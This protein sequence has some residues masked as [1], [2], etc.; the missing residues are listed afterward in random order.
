MAKLSNINGKF[1]VED[2]GA[3]RFSNQT[4]TTGQIL[5]SN[6][7]AAPTWVD[8]S[9]V[10][11]GPYLPLAG[12]ILT[13]AT[14]TASGISFTV[15]GALTGTTATFTG[16]VTGQANSNTFGTASASGR[17]LIVQAGSS[18]QAIMLKNNL[19]GDGTISATGT[20]TTMN[21]S[22]GTYSVAAL[23]IQNDGNVGIGTNSPSTKLHLGGTAPGDSI[24][25]QDSTTSGTNWEIGE[26]AAGKWQIFEDDGDSIVATFMSIGRVGIGNPS[27]TYQLDV[28][29]SGG[30]GGI[31]HV[32]NT[33]AQQYPRLAIQ[34]DVK[35]Y[36]IGVG[37]SGAAAGY[38]NNLY[39][40]D[41]N[42]AAIRMVIDTS[43]NVGIGVSSPSAKLEVAGHINVINPNP[44]IWIGESGSG[45]GGGFIGWNDAGD[46]LFLGHSYGS[47]FNKNIVINSSGNVGIGTDSPQRPLHVNG[48]EGVARFTSTASGNNGFEVGIGTA[49]QAFLWQTENSYMHFATNGTEKMRIEAGGN[50]GIGITST[51]SRLTVSSST[52]NNVANFKSS[53][54]TAY[55]AISDNSSSSA[56]GNQIGVVG[57]DMYFAVG[58]V[59]RMRL[60]PDGNS[61]FVIIKA[62]PATY[63]SKSFITLYGTNS[64]TYG[65]SV[66]ARSSI[67]SE[68]D[69]SAYGAN[70]KFYTNDSSNVEQT[71]L[72]ISSNG[73]GYYYNRFYLVSAANQGDLFFG[74]SDNQYNI[75]G[76]G[77]YGYMGYNTGGYH[78]FLTSGTQRMRILAN[79][80]VIIGTETSTSCTLKVSST[81]NGSESDP[82]FCITGN[83]YTALHFLNTTAYYIVQNSVGRSIRIV[84][85]TNGVKLDPGATAW[86]SNS[87]IALKENIKPLE[88]VLDKIKDYRCV[89]YNLKNAPE[90]K[91]IG[92]I[93][94]DWVDDFPAIVDKDEKDMLGMK[95][96][97]TIPVLLK[98]IQELKEEIEI[99]KNK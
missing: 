11:G 25:R 14:S 95:Y 30:N 33:D 38:K 2:T 74:T 45:G 63:N 64:S 77:T 49:S 88:N 90:D 93:A 5:K 15:G 65:G 39:F 78:R 94:Q 59:E 23:F 6:G 20:A 34:S 53:D 17:A 62:K 50:I 36:H 22:F 37:G 54:G 87:D 69:G 99:L 52:S 16:A 58:D 91:K 13:G 97:E 18:N 24:I 47:A 19:G 68:T 67:S 9:T 92:F 7:N 21:Y 73:F 35:G 82:H 43:G 8:G 32:K 96:T 83:G 75:F 55:I 70:L 81:K 27:P 61:T 26:R 10:I 3:I 44:Y 72:Q 60:V 85:N 28:L 66:I 4:G 31:I 98:A 1:A 56:L 40:Y 12:G 57:D 79:G 84:S 46:Y 89:E 71:R 86:T 48:T 80:N 76:G 41:N 42:T 51:D 29:G